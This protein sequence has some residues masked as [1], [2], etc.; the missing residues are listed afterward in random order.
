MVEKYNV[1]LEQFH[2]DGFI[3]VKPLFDDSA[4]TDIKNNVQRFVHDVVPT[5]PAARVYYEDRNDPTTLKQVQKIFEYDNYFEALMLQSVVREIAENLLQDDVIPINM[6]YFNKP[7]G[8]NTPTP[9]H[10]DGFYFHLNPCEAVTGWLALDDVDEENGCVHYVRGS[11]HST[12]LR[13]HGKTGV[14]GFSQGITDFGTPTDNNNS[15]CLPGPAGT[16][17]MHHARTIHFAGANQSLDRSRRAL[18]FI[19]Y[20]KRAR[21]DIAAKTAYQAQLDTQLAQTGKI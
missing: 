5:L 6:Q 12:Q 9:A 14:L 1:T 8:N 3:A 20:A 19:Y 4:I 7:P 13:P 16:F 21:E 10:Q 2:Q 18:G 11:H 15:V 17:L